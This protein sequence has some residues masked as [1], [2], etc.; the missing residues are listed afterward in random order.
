MNRADLLNEM[1]NSVGNQDPIEFFKKLPDVFNMLFDRI[2][3]LEA[4]L[5]QVRTQTALAVQW[6]PA[7]AADMLVKQIAFLR[8]DKETYFDEINKLMTAYAQ[9]LVTQNYTDFVSFWK[10]TLG[11]H[12]FLEYK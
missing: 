10:E 6:E 8:Q 9:D 5:K 11:Y 7:V 3:S 4:Q 12:P 1:K 2:D